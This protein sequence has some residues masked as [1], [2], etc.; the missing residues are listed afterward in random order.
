ML[1]RVFNS[2]TK[3]VTEGALILAVSTLIS[4]LLGLAREWLLADKFGA[5]R[6]LDIYFTAFKVPDLIYNVLIAGGII[7]AFLPLFSEYFEKDK[8]KAWRF[9]SNLLNIFLFLLII[10]SFLLFIFT[11][12]LLGFIA[13]GFSLEA[14]EQC[15]TLT[16]LMF[17]SPIFFGLSSIF[18]G[19]LHYFNRFL[20]YS[21]SPILYNLGIIFGILLFV[22]QFGVLGVSLGVILGA[23]FHLIIQVPSAVACGFNYKALFDLRAPEIKRVFFLMLPRALGNTAQQINFIVINA[24]ASTLVAGSISIFNFANNIQAIPIGIIGVAFAM[25][26]FPRFTRLQAKAEKQKFIDYF[27]SIFL[28][29]F[30]LIIPISFLIFIFRNSIVDLILVHGQFSPTSAQLTAA[31]LGIF[32][33]GLWASTL[34]PLLLRGFFALQDTKTPTLIA[35][36][37]MLINIVLSFTFVYQLRES[38][39]LQTFLFKTLKL[40]ETSG[41]EVLGLPLALSISSLFQFVLL[42]I[43]LRKKLSRT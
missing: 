8:E 28:K 26:A 37:A 3:T 9:T 17:L 13:P 22:P 12:Q 25:A 36:L 34:I 40:N 29:V 20:V 32:C 38:I 11:P 39:S 19:I 6:D 10:I 42:F 5:G 24:I 31:S 27:F 14:R 41:F 23:F 16:R 18:S 15:I 7:V 1:N 30:Y 35:I 2:Q 21:L 33:L 4:R 43:F